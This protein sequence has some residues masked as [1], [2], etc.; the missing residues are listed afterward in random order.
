M[1][2]KTDRIVAFFM[3][4]PSLLLVGLF[5]YGFI[6][7]AIQTSMTDWG[8][9]PNIPPMASN[10]VKSYVGM[11]NYQSIMTDTMEFNFRNAL[12]NTFFFTLFFVVGCVVLGMILALLL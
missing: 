10:V 1:R 8:V 12:T 5:V 3:L 11:Q 6:F 9:N 7:Q 4:L 2:S